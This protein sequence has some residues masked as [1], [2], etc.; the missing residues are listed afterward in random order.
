MK[1]NGK[2]SGRKTAVREPN[3]AEALAIEQAKASREGRRA[4][5]QVQRRSGTEAHVVSLDA[6]HSDA[7]GG[8][9]HLAETFATRSEDFVTASLM[10]LANITSKGSGVSIPHL[11]AS[12]AIIGAINPADELEAALAAQIAATHDLSLEMVNRAR[13]AKNVDHLRDYGNLATK[14]QRTLTTQLKAL[15]DW[16]RGGEQVVRHVHVYEG[17]QA[18]VAEQV[19]VGGR[20]HEITAQPYEPLAALS[21]P[22]PAGNP[23]PV[24][25]G[26]RP[27]AL[28]ASRRGEGIGRT[29]RKQERPEARRRDKGLSS[30]DR[31]TTSA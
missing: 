15:S 12:L 9:I 24:P 5:A 6:N 17:G 26:S 30:D 19:L 27:E 22:H 25:G 13:T 8:A 16:R 20:P 31:G 14:L 11:N 3:E 7:Q 1:R 28:P 23:L 18:V 21:G 10:H 29:D 2:Q 4:R